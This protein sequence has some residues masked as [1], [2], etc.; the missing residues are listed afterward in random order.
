[1]GLEKTA[2]LPYMSVYLG[3]G[4]EG[5][6]GGSPHRVTPGPLEHIL[7]ESCTLTTLFSLFNFPSSSG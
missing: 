6:A 7:V 3:P 4:G 5:I 1:M 2:P